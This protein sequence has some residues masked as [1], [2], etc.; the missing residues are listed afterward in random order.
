VFGLVSG[1]GAGAWI[2]GSPGVPGCRAVATASS[3]RAHMDTRSVPAEGLPEAELL[4]RAV[5][6]IPCCKHSATGHL[7]P[8]TLIRMGR[9][10]SQ[11]AWQ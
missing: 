4:A 2:E 6:P 8:A 5:C 3:A 1:T 7:L 9:H 11:G 10:T